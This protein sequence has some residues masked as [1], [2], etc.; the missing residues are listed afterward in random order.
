M[1]ACSKNLEVLHLLLEHGA[2]VNQEDADKWTAIHFAALNGWKEG[3]ELLLEKGARPNSETLHHSTPL[4]LAVKHSHT[5]VAEVLVAAKA[6]CRVVD[7]KGI[8]LLMW[9][10]HTGNIDIMGV[11][12]ICLCLKNHWMVHG[13]SLDDDLVCFL[14][15]TL[16]TATH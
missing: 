7:E 5:D 4:Q 1:A 8:T 11:R 12:V 3:T 6:D 9:A 13:G 2:V 10:A 16:P 15:I 14:L